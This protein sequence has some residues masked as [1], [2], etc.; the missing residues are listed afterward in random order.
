MFER[1]KKSTLNSLQLKE[2][3][4]SGSEDS[5]YVALCGVCIQVPPQRELYSTLF[6]L[7]GEN[8]A[9]VN[10]TDNNKTKLLL[11]WLKLYRFD[12]H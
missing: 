9:V 11:A 12:K 7:V 10:N 2:I 5:M 8:F 4:F 3:F 6:Q 1:V